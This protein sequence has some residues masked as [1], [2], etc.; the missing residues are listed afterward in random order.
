MQR[1]FEVDGIQYVIAF[2][3][4][5]HSILFYIDVLKSKRK[6]YEQTSLECGFGDEP[7]DTVWT[8]SEHTRARNIFRILPEVRT[9]IDNVIARYK[10]YYFTYSAN[11]PEKERVYRRFAHNIANRFGYQLHELKPGSFRFYKV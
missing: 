4:A 8:I 11:E 10:P 7:P 6:V 2:S 9:F 1:E 3:E 5:S